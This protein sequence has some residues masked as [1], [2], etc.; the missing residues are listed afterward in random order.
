MAVLDVLLTN[1]PNNLAIPEWICKAV[2]AG[3]RGTLFAA[4]IP[5]LAIAN[6]VQRD[7]EHP[8]LH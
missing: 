5:E 2:Y 7:V 4:K 1:N 8:S 6:Q 3:L